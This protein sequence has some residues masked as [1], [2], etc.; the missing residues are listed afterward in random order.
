MR[1]KVWKKGKAKGEAHYLTVGRHLATY[2]QCRL[3][4]M[5]RAR[6]GGD[7]GGGSTNRPSI[8]EADN[9]REAGT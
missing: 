1:N 3:P 9:F 8:A 4:I 2:R 7:D 6:S 5:H